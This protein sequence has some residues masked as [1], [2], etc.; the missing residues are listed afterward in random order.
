MKPGKT[1]RTS[2]E[3]ER[4][5][6]Q[7]GPH[8]LSG[9]GFPYRSDR[10]TNKNKY[11]KTLKKRVNN[12]SIPKILYKIEPWWDFIPIIFIVFL[13]GILSLIVPDILDQ[14]NSTQKT[15]I[16]ITFSAIIAI[17]LILIGYRA[18]R[19]MQY[20][21]DLRALIREMRDN[22]KRMDNFPIKFKEAYGDCDNIE[23]NRW[24]EKKSSYTNWGD[25]NN[26]HLKYLPSQAYFNFI[27]KGYINQQEKSLVFPSESIAHFYQF[28]IEFS[29]DL[30]KIE[31]DIRELKANR[32]ETIIQRK[33]SHF[34]TQTFHCPQE[35]CHFL[36]E[37]MYPF[38]ARNN[39]LN[40][41]ILN[42]Y[43]KTIISLEGHE[44][45][46]EDDELINTKNQFS[47]SL[48]TRTSRWEQLKSDLTIINQ[49]LNNKSNKWKVGI[50]LLLFGLPAL[51]ILI[52]FL[53]LNVIPPQYTVT[54]LV[55][56]F[57]H[58]NA[59][60]IFG[61]NYIHDVWLPRHIVDNLIGYFVILYIIVIFY[62]IVIPI[63][64]LHNVLRF[65]Y[66]DSAFF[67][68]IIILLLGL[69]FV[70]SGI[71][72]YF[73]RISSQTGNWGFSGII[74]GFLAYLFFLILLTMYDFVL[75]K[76]AEKRGDIK[77]FNDKK[78]LEKP[79]T[80]SNALGLIFFNLIIVII[81]IYWILSEIGDKKIGVFG[82]L[83]GFTFGLIIATLIMMICE[84]T[85]LKTRIAISFVL[86]L[87]LVI[88]SVFWLFFY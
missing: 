17:S 33:F 13:I 16:T 48:I 4:G 10:N 9:L 23:V 75:S 58:P 41:G 15:L 25:G 52:Q 31:N 53:I 73:G 21:Y 42:E 59:T 69:P 32:S 38:Y 40:T 34:P 83:A 80:M 64:Q 68:T 1:G 82:H 81:P 14:F 30:Q 22:C 35:I 61:S 44:W 67:G 66:S 71:S 85:R 51:V 76:L 39:V 12:N 36:I 27:N 28:C 57:S 24:I 37:N 79:T 56:N 26:F 70:V 43:E 8:L 60:A 11:I 74:Y 54:H 50:C 3:P 20:F 72:I 77:F 84:R 5:G 45:L 6:S 62:Y 87:I 47:D 55:L 7:E 49:S 78:S 46:L 86:F 65:N 29:V 88:P 19:R 18:T 63:G 2:E